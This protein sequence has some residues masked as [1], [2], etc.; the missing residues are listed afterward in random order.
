ML[1]LA[2]SIPATI[3]F[4]KSSKEQFL[5]PI[6]Q[7]ILVALLAVASYLLTLIFSNSSLSNELFF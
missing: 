4:F 5:T 6:V 3:I 7:I 2:T 1:N